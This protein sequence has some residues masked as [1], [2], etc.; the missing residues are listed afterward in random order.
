MCIRDSKERALYLRNGDDVYAGES[1][2]LMRSGLRINCFILCSPS[3]F[4][5]SFLF[6]SCFGFVYLNRN[7]TVV[8][9]FLFCLHTRGNRGNRALLSEI[10]FYF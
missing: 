4:V 2:F 5:K 3:K 7:V 9:L 10:F 6:F 8:L 1:R